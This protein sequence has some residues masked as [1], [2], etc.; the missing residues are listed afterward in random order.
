MTSGVIM[1][2]Q[3]MGMEFDGRNVTQTSCGEQAWI[4]LHDTQVLRVDEN[5]AEEIEV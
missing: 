2:D 5:T 4:L 3:A 1:I